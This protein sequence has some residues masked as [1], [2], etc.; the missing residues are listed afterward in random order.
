MSRTMSGIPTSGGGGD[1][2]LAGDPNAFTGTNTYD[3]N[4]PTSTLA[5]TPAATDFITKQ[6]GEN[7]FTS[8]TGDALLAGNNVFTGTNKFDVNRPTST[9]TNT[10]SATDFLTKQN[11]DTLY[12]GSAGDV[13]EGGNNVFTGTNS[14][15]T[16]RPTST[17]T[18]TIAATDFLT[19][20]NA[21]TLYG[22]GS[23]DA[24]LAAGTAANP[25]EF[26]G[27]CDFNGGSLQMTNPVQ[28]FSMIQTNTATSDVNTLAMTG[29]RNRF[30]QTSLSNG[31][32]NE[33][34]QT[35]GNNT[36]STISQFTPNS[37][38][39]QDTTTARILTK[40]KIGIGFSSA[41]STP[42]FP[43]HVLSGTTGLGGSINRTYLRGSDG[44]G[45]YRTTNWTN[46]QVSIFAEKVIMAGNF[47]GV[48]DVRIKKDIMDLPD[49]LPLI[50][51]IKPRTYKYRDPKIPD[52]MTYGFIAQ[53]LEEVLPCVIK[54]TTNKIPNILKTADV[55]GGI[56][57]LKETTDLIVD[58]EIAIF[59]EQDIEYKVKIT[60]LISDKS[61]KTDI[62]VELKD[63]YFIYGIYVDDF[64]AVEH[65]CLL[66]IM[67]K[68]VQELNA[69]NKSLEDRLAIL[70]DKIN[71]MP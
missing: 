53:E 41:S 56:F 12:T 57:T 49:V 23:G 17:L 39:Y 16:N 38:I 61:F 71:N 43:L 24:V 58:D 4:R 14:F 15:N 52:I 13:Q 50:E 59:D 28:T 2:T 3:V 55:S 66:P 8:S 35:G 46:D 29:I 37:L 22:S 62:D 6:D 44:G 31:T 42:T 11:A 65:K 54:K 21:D 18:S 64:E 70:E 30:T 7:L 19:R 51:Q 5:T 67:M 34:K 1:V 47:L 32:I 9:L 33:F 69:K 40:G 27:V 10:I 45:P 48:S 25:Q 26:T 20:Q 60:E 36:S 63:K 68:G